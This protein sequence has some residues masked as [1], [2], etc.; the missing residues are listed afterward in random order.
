MR[1][2]FPMPRRMWTVKRTLTILLTVLPLWAP[3]SAALAQQTLRTQAENSGFTQYTRYDSMMVYLRDLKATTPEMYLSSYGTTW[4]GRELPYAVFS[5]PL[6][7]QPREAIASGKPILVFQT[8]VHGGERTQRE[9]VLILLRELVTPG[10]RLNGYL[11]DVILVV[12]PQ[13]NPDGFETGNNGSR[14]NAWGIDLNRDY[15]KLEQPEIHDLV[16]NIYHK[17]HPHMVI[18]GHNGGSRPYNMT[19]ITAHHPSVHQGLMDLNNNEIFQHV[20][21]RNEEAGLRAFWYPRG[22]A[23]FWA[24]AP[25]Y[26]RISMTYSSFMNALGITFESP[27]QPMEVGVR[28]GVISYAAALEW[29]VQN[30][31]K[32]LATVE[33][34]RAEA[35]RMGTVPGAQVAVEM[36]LVDYDYPITYDIPDPENSGEFRTVT[37]RLRQRPIATK[38]RDLP[39][40]YVLPREARDA[41]ALL[42]KHG[43]TVEML[44]R[45]VTLEV[46]A[47]TVEDVRFRAEYNHQAS[48][49]VTVGEVLT[50]QRQFPAGSFIV[51]TGQTMGRV[52]AHMLEV[53]SD[54][55]VVLWNRMDAWLPLARIYPVRAAGGGGAG[56]GGGG[57]QA[58]PPLVPIF[59]L[60]LATP[61]PTRLVDEVR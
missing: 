16:T 34:A 5:R 8:N 9:S 19:Y 33:E 57:A 13:V 55:N 24:G 45:Q 43:I 3:A 18:D 22:T 4:Q 6:V 51:R 17:W 21:V 40:A 53:E 50:L 61:L 32:M 12:V 46:Q 48:P 56:G 39:W 26:P 54:D 36:Q 1:P 49:V 27:A 58:L 10:T 31:A 7:S 20:R 23:E 35:K 15:I 59:K 52:V 37:G 30:R 29:V 14:G 42:R 60:M 25:A 41:V 28:S 2:T 11:D 44:E 38:T 47:Y